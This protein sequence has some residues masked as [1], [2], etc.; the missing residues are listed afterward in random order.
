MNMAAR[1]FV[2]MNT[3]VASESDVVG[4]LKKIKEVVSAT[5]IYGVYDIIAEIEAEDFEKIKYGVM[6]DIRAITEIRSTVTMIVADEVY[7]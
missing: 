2:L 7:K 4:E 5:L 6:E 3:E 1:A